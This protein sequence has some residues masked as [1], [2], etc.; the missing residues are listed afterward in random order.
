[1]NLV[2]FLFT[3]GVATAW[4]V[5][6]YES[7]QYAVSQAFLI[8]YFLLFNVVLMLP[9]RQLG[10]ELEADVV[11]AS[12]ARADRWVNGS[13]LFGLPTV[14]FVLQ[15]GLVR[16]VPFGTA[17]SALVLAAFYVGMASLM[18]G[19]S[20]LAVTFEASLAIAVVFLT[21]VIPFALSA[22]ST[23]GAW[24]LEAAGLVW[25]GWRQGRRLPRVFGYLLTLLAG[26][27]LALAWVVLAVPQGIFNTWFL[28]ALLLALG[29]VAAALFVQRAKQAKQANGANSALA[30]SM[31]GESAAEPLLVAWGLL[32]A[33]VAVAV[34]VDLFVPQRYAFAAWL[35]G[36]GAIA[37][38]CTAA[39]VRLR[40]PGIAV[41]TAGL[42]PL[43]GVVLVAGVFVLDSPASFGGWWA[44]PLA[45][46]AQLVVLRFAAPMWP[47]ALR[48]IVHTLGLLLL[49]T[50]GALQGSAITRGW[51]DDVGAWPWL[52]WLVLPAVLLALLVRPAA[53]RV[54]P[55]RDAPAAYLRTAAAVLAA[56]LVGWTLLANVF[57]TGA[58][59]PLP[60]APLLNPL[61]L[62]IGAALLAAWAWAR[63][64]AG[65]PLFASAPQTPLV[66]L[67]GAGFVWLNAML[68]R[69]FHHYAGVPYRFDDWS[70][71]LAVQT[72]V[73]LLWSA[74]ALF[75]MWLAARRSAR[76]P[77]IAGAVLLGAVV[78]KLLLV[79]LSGTGT[80]TRIV[81]FIGVGVLM[82]VIG[83]VAPL[84]A[85]REAAAPESEPDPEE[86]RRDAS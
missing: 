19:R 52:G 51:G 4:G 38:L 49:A 34:Q 41:P 76:V 83:Y 64:D 81:S 77:W 74:T 32:W 7:G 31:P 72:G 67:A 48:S 53:E 37:L 28:N 12:A 42:V 36:L 13:L 44:W 54:W 5:L 84:P 43:A 27:A 11:A 22:R 47:P 16:D 78:A 63:S 45:L 21:L 26:G 66:A 10:A 24:A 61:D 50:F 18:R 62:G 82:L 30:G 73:T 85:A 75:T 8:A 79:D 15:H 86:T 58:A 14:A 55:V 60:H 29:G 2:G 35:A 56:A 3:F 23:A 57:S 1:M 25:L 33:L 70:A 20:R 59:T 69:G 71:S 80:I 9:A 65:R 46:L 39:A 17:I 40:W 6:S 68:V